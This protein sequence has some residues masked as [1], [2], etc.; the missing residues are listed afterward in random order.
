LVFSKKKLAFDLGRCCQCGCCLAACERGALEELLNPDGLWVIQWKEELCDF[1]GRC[2]SVCPASVLPSEPLREEDWLTA[3]GSFLI[4]AKNTEVRRMASSGGVARTLLAGLV[5]KGYVDTG[6]T[7]R[8]STIYPWAEGSFWYAPVDLS[9]MPNSIYLPILA[10]KNFKM[11]K[12]LHSIFLIGT[13]CQLRAAEQLIKKKAEKVIK[14]ALYCKQQKTLGFARFLAK[15]L[16]VE[17][18]LEKFTPISFRGNGWPGQVNI[19][20]KTMA[21]EVIAAL[22][23][24]K[25]LWRVPG[26]RFCMNP[27]GVNVDLTLADP[28]E[29]EGHDSLG[30]TLVL[31][32]TQEGLRTISENEDLL[33]VE[34]V[35]LSA[36]MKSMGWSNV[37]RRQKLVDFYLGRDVGLRATISGKGE[38][39]QTKVLERLL[40]HYKLPDFLYKVLAHL[41]DMGNIL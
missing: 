41:P 22:P 6:Y 34:P 35:N 21:Y 25:R 39:L 32:W 7:L 12:P 2:V 1:C 5:N 37:K 15:R 10:Y 29:I 17:L 38:Q 23:F 26:C 11:D 3:Q 19:E 31:A 13:A 20:H 24:G 9:A 36:A 30:K 14:V 18:D 8:K 4:Y 28:W 27:A 16:G 33:S 40:S